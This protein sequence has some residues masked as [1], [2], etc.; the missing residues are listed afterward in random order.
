MSKRPPL[1]SNRFQQRFEAI[2]ANVSRVIKGKPDVIRLALVAML[3]EGHVLFEDVPGVGKSMLARAIGRSF[4]ATVG[5][6][7]CTPDMLPGDITGSS[8]LDQ[9]SNPLNAATGSK[10]SISTMAIGS[11][12][13][14]RANSHFE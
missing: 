9:R 13:L 8:V 5:R 7:Q 4:D 11:S 12:T 2:H 14:L 3:S 10:P 1:D 6:I